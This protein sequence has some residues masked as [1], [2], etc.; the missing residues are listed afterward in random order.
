VDT[1]KQVASGRSVRSNQSEALRAEA[2]RL[3]REETQRLAS[4]TSLSKREEEVLAG[5]MEGYGPPEQAGRD[6]LSV[7][8]VRTQVKSVLRKLGVR[9]QLEAVAH[10]RRAGWSPPSRA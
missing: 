9:S 10:A 4:F 8:T 1:V 3:A 2:H 5:L 6:L 7:Q